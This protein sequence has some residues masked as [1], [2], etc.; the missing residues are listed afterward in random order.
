MGG[1]ED[2]TPTGKRKKPKKPAPRTKLRVGELLKERNKEPIDLARA[3]GMNYP[4]QVYEY[5]QGDANP[6]LARLEQ[7]AAALS[8]FGNDRVSISDL[9][10]EPSE[11]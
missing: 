8:N 9:L 4:Q 2:L 10:I 3:L 6:Q 7:I 11:W 5:L 1:P